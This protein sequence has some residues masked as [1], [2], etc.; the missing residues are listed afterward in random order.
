MNG[1]LMNS[2]ISEIPKNTNTKDTKE[3][4]DSKMNRSKVK[5]QN[6]HQQKEIGAGRT[7]LVT[8]DSNRRQKR[9]NHHSEDCPSQQ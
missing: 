5:I 4:C 1:L 9:R 3:S 6:C 7:H 2:K 8:A